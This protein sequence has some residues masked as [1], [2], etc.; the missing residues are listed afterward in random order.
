M[1][2]RG[3][4]MSATQIEEAVWVEGNQYLGFE[5]LEKVAQDQAEITWDKLIEFLKAQK[6]ENHD[7]SP[8]K[9]LYDALGLE[10]KLRDWNG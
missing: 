1:E 9:S 8:G 2:V 4:V 5:A 10:E 3:T 7:G 6:V